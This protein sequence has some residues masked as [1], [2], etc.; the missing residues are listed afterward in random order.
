MSN[1]FTY[2]WAR[3]GALS[4]IELFD[5]D[6]LVTTLRGMLKD[7]ELIHNKELEKLVI[8]FEKASY[9]ENH[10]VIALEDLSLN[11]YFQTA[12]RVLGKIY[13]ERKRIKA[14]PT[15]LRYPGMSINDALA[16]EKAEKDKMNDL[17]YRVHNAIIRFMKEIMFRLDI[18]NNEYLYIGTMAFE[19][20][21][22]AGYPPDYEDKE[23]F[24]KNSDIYWEI[25]AGIFNQYQDV[26]SYKQQIYVMGVKWL[27]NP[28]L[29]NGNSLT[30][31]GTNMTT[32]AFFDNKGNELQIKNVKTP[33]SIVFP[34]SKSTGYNTEF[35]KCHYFDTASKNFKK[36]GCSHAFVPDV[37]LPC[38]T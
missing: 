24:I 19:F 25:P 12:E 11:L 2:T 17:G 8:L 32:F 35:L 9:M 21:V 37:K 38:T 16:A 13:L 33:V 4:T 1:F 10:K 36:D 15:H 18:T 29:L 23:F 22:S 26:A 20:K 7:P 30:Q 6:I 34:Y 3:Y 31:V 28:H 27:A 14:D 5:F